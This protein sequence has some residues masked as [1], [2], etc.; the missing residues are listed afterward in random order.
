MKT[1]NRRYRGFAFGIL[2]ICL[3]LLV[4]G[5]TIAASEDADP[6]PGLVMAQQATRGGKL[7]IT[8]DH[9][10]F[11]QLQKDFTS[12]RE[13]TAACISCHSEAA[14]QFHQT[15]HWQWRV[16]DS[17]KNLGKGG[18]SLNNFCISTNNM[19]D[20]GCLSCH[21]G[22]KGKEEEVNC[23]VCHGQEEINWGEAFEDFN[24]FS[25]EEDDESKEMAADIQGDIQQAAQSIARP[26]RKNC[27]SCHFYGGGGD[28]VKHG[29]LDSSMTKPNK[30]LDVHMGVDGQN[31]NCTRCHT[32]VLHNIA[33]RVYTTPA[34]ENRK[35]LIEDDLATKITCESCHSD[36]PHKSATKPNDH[37][38]KVACQTCHIPTFA[39]VNPTK[40]SWDWSQAGKRKDGKPYTTEDEFGKHDYMS[41][42][43][44]M[45]WAKNVKPE[46]FWYNGSIKA[47]TVRDTVDP[48]GTVIVSAPVGNPEDKN[49]RIYPFKVHRGK[50]PYD[51]VHKN[52]LAPIVSGKDGFFTT[53]DWQTTL[54][55]GMAAFDMPYSGEYGFVETSYVFPTTHMVAPRENVVNC[56]ECHV[57]EGGRLA[58]LAGVYMPGR[59]INHPVDAIGWIAVL[60]ALVGVLV[61]G[62]CRF[63]TNGNGRKQEEHNP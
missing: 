17:Q 63:F 21:P 41:I 6:A 43:G 30:A 8:A 26:T 57:R 33:G 34:A 32:T 29:D 23:L 16:K 61:H 14:D 7:W 3:L 59:D 54:K 51:R 18:D 25:S 22:W 44:R 52:L 46:Y 28:G 38:D 58:S 47:L 40:M 48:A 20:K 19:T 1:S 12:G 9:T 10:K 49:A 13:V 42:K 50:Q 56:A 27:G 62:L 35:S 31:F 24:A 60:G 15:I 2:Q 4:S 37:T 55:K 5:L 36:T 11:K 39:R 45:K 53:M